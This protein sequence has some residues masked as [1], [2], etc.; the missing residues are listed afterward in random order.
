[1]QNVDIYQLLLELLKPVSVPLNEGERIE[2]DPAGWD[3]VF[4][5][6][7]V[8]SVTPL[9]YDRLKGRGMLEIVPEEMRVQFKAEFRKNALR[10]LA[11][12]SELS[13]I[14]KAFEAEGIPILLLKGA[15]L[16]RGVYETAGLRVVGDLDLLVPRQ[17]MLRSAELIQSIGYDGSHVFTE[18]WINSFKHLP[19]FVKR[20]SFEK[21]ELH[22]TIDDFKKATTFK[23]DVFWDESVP[24]NVDE[25]GLLALS[26]ENL[27]LH[28]C[29]HNAYSHLFEFSLRPYCDL[30]TVIARCKDNLDWDRIVERAI[31]WDW[32]RGVYLSLRFAA[33]CLAADVPPGVLQRLMSDQGMEEAYQ[34]V[35]RQVRL[36]GLGGEVVLANLALYSEMNAVQRGRLILQR[37]FP[38]RLEMAMKYGVKPDLPGILRVYPKR[39]WFILRNYSRSYLDV[40]AGKGTVTDSAVQ[41]AAI[42]RWLYE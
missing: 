26:P 41:K 40:T 1:M 27:I 19:E 31:E 28:L 21:V 15:H 38:A 37:L 5:L 4:Q 25:T 17:D 2:L 9:L 39:W 16:A 20:G 30:Q 8:Q 14:S 32:A 34:V 42:V 24:A 36:V 33:E 29:F 13:R 23:I 3:Q 12:Y 10:N 6:A 7:A 22:S 11:L 35:L 18:D